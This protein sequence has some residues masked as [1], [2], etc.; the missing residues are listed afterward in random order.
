MPAT[1]LVTGAAGFL[2]STLVDRLLAEGRRVVGI[3]DLSGGDL[4]NLATARAEHP[5]AFEFHRL[6]V[7]ADG[8]DAMVA[9][10]RPAVVFHLAG[11]SDRGASWADPDADAR[12]RVTGT[13]RVLRA[14]TTH[15][16]DKV[17]LASDRLLP[18]GIA[19]TPHDVSCRAAEAHVRAW[20][21]HHGLRWTILGI[22]NA[23]GPRGGRAG[24]PGVVA[25]WLDR[26]AEGQ[27]AGTIHGDGQQARD[28][29]FVDDVVDAF[30]RSVQSG[31]GRRVDVG[32]GQ[33]V[34]VA[35]VHGALRVA[36]GSPH[37]PV[38]GPGRDGD[39]SHPGVDVG[40]AQAALGW[41]PFTSLEQ[42]LA[43]TVRHRTG[44]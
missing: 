9:R 36:T 15:G 3:D 24:A 28:L 39:G 37:D 6:D 1:V 19:P 11:R 40:P 12:P 44:R 4:A 22:A 33:A 17:V 30:A 21:E 7:C 20:A 5:G 31:D 16:V 32:S 18:D 27:R 35:A 2:G 38:S 13:L 43:L 26:M 10:H 34:P 23:Y 25:T 8:F 14:A 42:G 29:V 41:R